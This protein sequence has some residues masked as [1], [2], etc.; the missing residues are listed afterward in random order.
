[1]PILTPDNF[2]KS[3]PKSKR[4]LAI[5][6]GTKTIGLASGDIE[7]GIASPL[8]TIKRKKFTADMNELSKW[9]SD[10]DIGAIIMGL[11]L[12]M[13]GSEGKRCQSTRDF[14]A[15]LDKFFNGK[16]PIYFCDERLSTYEAETFLIDE[17]DMNRA[18][19]SEIIDKMAAQRIMTTALN[20]FAHNA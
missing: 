15:E 2:I 20:Y 19:R 4:W 11:P 10:Y 1:M 8:H 12:N 7:T 18:R 13:D 3:A 17:V 9:L 5:D 16:Y 6:L 14:T